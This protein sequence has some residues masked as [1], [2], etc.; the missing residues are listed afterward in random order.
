MRNHGMTL[1]ELLVVLAILALMATVA[2]TSTDVLLSQG[3]YEATTRTL[4]N[5][6]DSV[7]GPPNA[8]QA[9]GTLIST[10][11]VADLGGALVCTGTD[12]TGLSE[13]WALPGG[14]APFGLQA[15]SDPDVV[16]PCGWRGPYLRLPAGQSG[17]LDGWGNPFDL[18]DSSG[19]PVAPGGTIATVQSNGSGSNG[20]YNAPLSVSIQPPPIAVAG[21]VYV[22]SSSGSISNPPSGSQVY[23]RLFGPNPSTGGVQ[24]LPLTVTTGTDGVV[25]FAMPS[26]TAVYAPGFL[27]AY[28]GG[29]T[30]AAATSR[31]NIV[32]F[33]RSEA[34]ITLYL[35]SSGT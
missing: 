7:L 13:L 24:E 5:I 19:N 22:Q 16:V 33:V 21:Y 8:R 27:R 35:S 20:P 30:S 17:L 10:G 28:L 11:F 34:G 6:Q 29:S 3:R 15:T 26:G 25:S 18:L 23:V 31:S 2:V 32:Q 14:V 4:A 9:D 12:S 1:L